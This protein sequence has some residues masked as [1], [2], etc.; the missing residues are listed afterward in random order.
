MLSTVHKV[1]AQL[2][3]A[4]VGHELHATM[5]RLFPI[6]RSI[7][8]PGLRQTLALLA[9][10]VPGLSVHGVA[11]LSQ[12]FDWTVPPEWRIRDAWIKGPDGDKIVDFTRCN[13][14]VVNYSTPVRCTLSLEELRPHLYSL[15]DQ[16]DWIPYRTSYYKRDWG[17]CLA[18][19]QL[20]R[21]RPGQYE[22]C[23]DADLDE[24][25]K[26]EWGEALLP[27]ESDEEILLSTHVCHPS[28]CN[29]NLSG[30][31]VL[32]ALARALA[33]AKRR[34]SYRIL[35]I[36][37]GIGSVAWLSQ[38][39]ER[40]SRIRHGLVLNCLGDEAPFTYKLSRRGDAE[41]DA[42]A[43]CALRD[44]RVAY[45]VI[46]FTPY[47]YDERNWCSA[48]FDLP[49]GSLTRSTHSTF[50]GYHSSGD[51]LD[52]VRPQVLGDSLAMYLD[53][54][55]VLERNQRYQ[56]LVPDAEAQ[57]GKRGLYG[58]QGGLPRRARP[59]VAML[60]VLNHSDGHHSLLDTAR[61]SG[62]TF[63]ELADAADTLLQHGLLRPV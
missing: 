43:R 48:R 23:V 40:V 5:A 18:H 1:R 38:N 14:H 11:S 21:L 27:G 52:L 35:F 29:D 63:E 16:P 36:P 37:G 41:V 45:R 60:W 19:R 59:E 32:A 30:V 24:G 34:Y 28:L 61:A 31:V 3:P 62:L 15:P 47:G 42:A 53:V 55:G 50:P 10:E 7:T 26:L 58:L 44:A 25:G 17:F 12:V 56:S 13:L 9:E 39:Q 49:V 54:L 22:V 46:G 6:C 57:L 51:D 20:E 8:G 4:A 33:G 2:D